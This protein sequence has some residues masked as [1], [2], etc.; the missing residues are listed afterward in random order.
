[1]PLPE[2]L[3]APLELQPAASTRAA[4]TPTPA[5]I[6]PH[7]LRRIIIGTSYVE[8]RVAGEYTAVIKYGKIFHV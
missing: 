5:V 7:R 2:L 4:V 8:H 3:L 6:P 1:V